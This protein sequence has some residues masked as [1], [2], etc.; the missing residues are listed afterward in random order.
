MTLSKSLIAIYIGHMIRN[1]VPSDFT[2]RDISVRGE[3]ELCDEN[4]IVT[5][6][7]KGS[8]SSFT[9]LKKVCTILNLIKMRHLLG[10]KK[11]NYL[12]TSIIFTFGSTWLFLLTAILFNTS[13]FC[14]L[15]ADW[16]IKMWPLNLMWTVTD[17][18][19]D[20]K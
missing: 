5:T 3:S 4:K 17:T 8:N 11:T 2:P 19:S 18:H 13:R 14:N 1:G 16:S 15:Y 6:S 7:I 10:F 12:L 9:I 20:S